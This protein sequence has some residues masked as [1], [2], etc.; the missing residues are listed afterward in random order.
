MLPV[1]ELRVA[2]AEPSDQLVIPGR[3]LCQPGRHDI[4]A[5][6]VQALGRRLLHSLPSAAAARSSYWWRILS[7]A[8]ARESSSR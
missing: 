6:P 1:H 3:C 4:D 2:D 5:Q 7:M 8:P